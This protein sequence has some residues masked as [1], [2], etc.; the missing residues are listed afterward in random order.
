MVHHKVLIREKSK[1]G[2]FSSIGSM[3]DIEGN[4]TI[5]TYCSIHSNCHL[6]FGTTIGDYVFIA[7]FTVTTNGN[8]MGYK[9]PQLIEKFGGEKGPT[10]GSGCQIAVHVTISPGITLGPECVVAANAVV[11]KDFEAL[12]ILMG[13]PAQ[14]KGVVEELHRLPEEIRKTIG[15]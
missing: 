9:R 11:T 15:L 13:T 12:S 1:I 5:G 6:C 7:P 2:D 3:C 8:P 10:I 14:K 4:L